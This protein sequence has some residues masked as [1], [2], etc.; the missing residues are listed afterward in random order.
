MACNT[1]FSSSGI[2]LFPGLNAEI[3]NAFACHPENQ[4]L[5]MAPVNPGGRPKL[6]WTAARKRKLTRL[7]LLT[8]VRT[9][10]IP[11]LLRGDGFTPR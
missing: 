3:S 10:D 8:N 7:Y 6:A 1:V 9:K 11:R 5:K 2:V 4:D